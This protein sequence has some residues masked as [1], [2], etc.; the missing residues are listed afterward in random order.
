MSTFLIDASALCK[1]YFVNEIGG[2]LVNALFQQVTS[3]RY[4]LNLAIVEVLNAF[5]RVQREG[6]LLRRNGMALSP[7]FT[8]TSP[9]VMC[10][11]TAC[12]TTIFSGV[13][14]FSKLCKR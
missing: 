5:Y 7:P 11:S 6:Y 13:N 9:T 1:R 3:T 8:M 2:D 12:A 14:R 10:S 4:I